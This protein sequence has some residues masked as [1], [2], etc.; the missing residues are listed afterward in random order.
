M[1]GVKS[2]R[3]KQHGAFIPYRLGVVLRRLSIEGDVVIPSCRI[4]TPIDRHGSPWK[5]T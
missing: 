2:S 4:S 3:I 5:K 1:F